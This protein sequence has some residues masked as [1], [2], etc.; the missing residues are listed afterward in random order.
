MIST[1]MEFLSQPIVI[2][3]IIGMV[4]KKTIRK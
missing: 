2:L 4:M 1:I 3:A